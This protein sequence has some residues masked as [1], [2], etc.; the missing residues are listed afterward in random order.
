MKQYIALLF[1]FFISANCAF[2]TTLFKEMNKEKV[3]N[4]LIISPLSIFQ[5]LSLTA[6]GARDETLSQMLEVLQQ[7]NLFRL[8]TV[9][10]NIIRLIRRFTTLSTANAVMTRFSPLEGFMDIA[11]RYRAPVQPLRSVEQVNK[12]V[13]RQTR[14][15]I[16][17]ILDSLD[18]QTLMILINAIYF[19]G[20]W[21]NKFD[22]EMTHPLPFFNL[23]KEEKQV[24]TMKITET[25]KYYEDANV[26]AVE[27]KFK[28]DSMSA[29]IIL[30]AEG[31]DINEYVNTLAESEEEYKKIIGGLNE[32]KVFLTLPKFEVSFGQE[33]KEILKRLGMTNAFSTKDADFSGLKD[34]DNLCISKVLHKTYMKVNEDG[35]EAAAATVVVVDRG[36]PLEKVYEMKVNRPFLFLLRNS[37]LPAGYDLVFMSKIEKI[38]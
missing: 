21:K 9:N 11:R 32:V 28:R 13:S 30:P 29:L 20:E 24:D 35:T 3:G 6:N 31:K 4:N 37:K 15:K 8:N 2:Q 10:Q 38:E 36:V 5:V 1:S 16:E 27:L 26:K 33:L 7:K 19:K 14:G 34:D 25:F 23:G 18:D 22:K 17:K 12:W